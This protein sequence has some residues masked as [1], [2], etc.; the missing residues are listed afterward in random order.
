MKRI[1][2]LFF[3]LSAMALAAKE[4][5][6]GKWISTPYKDG[7]QIIIEVYQNEDGK[8]YG[9]MI[10]QT[11]PTYQSGEKKGQEKTD[12]KNPDPA[13]RNRSLVGVELLEALVYDEEKDNYREGSVYIPGMGKTLYAKVQIENDVMKMKGSFDKSGLIGKTQIWNRFLSK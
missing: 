8:F 5:I 2:I 11:V 7:N 9:K 10:D 6:L 13:L 12:E 4:D 1:G 3:L